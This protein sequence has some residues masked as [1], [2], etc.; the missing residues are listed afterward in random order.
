M[1]HRTRATA[2]LLT[3]MLTLGIA[4]TALAAH[5]KPGKRYAGIIT[6]V[7]PI[8]GFSPPVSFTVSAGGTR[9]LNFTYGT[10]GCGGGVGGFKPG[11]DP[12]TSGSELK[13]AAIKVSKRGH[14]SISGSKVTHRYTGEYASELTTTTQVTGKFTSRTAASG[15]ISFSQVYTP[16]TGTGYSCTVS[17]PRLFKVT[18]K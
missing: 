5:P 6:N 18:I 2:A 9:L 15:T 4:A 11:V 14:F 16:T 7:P 8:E 13:V 12:Y 17:V 3:A 1:N 10:F